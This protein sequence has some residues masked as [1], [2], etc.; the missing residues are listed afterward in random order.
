[1]EKSPISVTVLFCYA[2]LCSY[3]WEAH[4]GTSG[5]IR[6]A[7]STL[8]SVG[9]AFLVCWVWAG[10]MCTSVTRVGCRYTLTP[11]RAWPLCLLAFYWR[12]QMKLWCGG[13]PRKQVSARLLIWKAWTVQDL[14]RCSSRHPLRSWR[15]PQTSTL[16]FPRI[17]N[18]VCIHSTKFK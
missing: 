6:L 4:S 12:T 18:P 9:Q 7:S 8:T 11:R 10:P 14:W 15:A 1:M 5:L 16:C 13:V 17:S 3:K 2:W